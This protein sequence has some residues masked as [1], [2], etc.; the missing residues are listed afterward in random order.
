[1][2]QTGHANDMELRS[3]GSE[4][5]KAQVLLANDLSKSLPETE[6]LLA[7]LK[8]DHLRGKREGTLLME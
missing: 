1:M 3:Q 5:R 6:S 8:K 2:H 4:L 7:K